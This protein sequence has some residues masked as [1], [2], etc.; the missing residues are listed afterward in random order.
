MAFQLYPT[1]FCSDALRRFLSTS[2]VRNKKEVKYAV[3]KNVTT[4]EGVLVPSEREGKV[5]CLD[6]F[7]DPRDRDPISRLGLNIRH[8]FLRPDGTVLPRRISGISC[9]SQIHL[10]LMIER[11]RKAGLLPVQIK[12]DGSH[13]Y[14]RRGRHRFNVYYDS[15]MIGLPRASKKAVKYIPPE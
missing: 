11:A 15:E 8:T 6:G 4:V 1:K 10:E 7:G 12:P 3:D 14:E 9:R 5:V 2:H 13:V